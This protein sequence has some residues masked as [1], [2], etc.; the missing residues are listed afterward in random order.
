MK[1]FFV[2]AAALGLFAAVP[3]LS[4]PDDNHHNDKQG[5]THQGAARPAPAA[6]ARQ[7]TQ[8]RAMSGQQQTRT[9]DTHQNNAPGGSAAAAGR[10]RSAGTRQNTPGG[11]ATRSAE[12]RQ[13]SRAVATDSQRYLP[14]S[15]DANRSQ[16]GRSSAGASQMQ[17]GGNNM[18]RNNQTRGNSGMSANANERRPS[19]NSLR[20]NLQASRQYHNGNYNAPQGYQ[21][22]HWSYGDRLPRGYYNRNYW[23]TDYLM[24]GLFAPPDGL[25]WVRVGDDALLVDEISGDVVQVDYGVFY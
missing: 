3:A 15:G 17:S 13:N 11:S 25:I 14:A 2:C 7:N 21:A 6:G 1:K 18:T 16:A 23:L 19:I 10:T 12:T 4:A 5:A 9:V 20:H 22:R 24:F 8:G